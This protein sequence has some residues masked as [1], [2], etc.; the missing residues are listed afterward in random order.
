MTAENA[1]ASIVNFEG[2]TPILRVSNLQ[3][4][5]SYYTEKLGFSVAFQNDLFGCIVRGRCRIFLSQ[6]DQGN[7]GN[8]LWI[9]VSD[10][11]QLYGEL[12][13][14]GAKLRHP[15]TNYSWACEFQVE[16]LDGNILRMGSDP[17]PDKPV[18]DWLDMYGQKWLPKRNGKWERAES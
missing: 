3:Q 2:T 17:L 9:G 16:D 1:S 13:K 5:L 11:V 4:S 7:A 15:P 6:D 18:G 12:E 8:W 14:T 10:A